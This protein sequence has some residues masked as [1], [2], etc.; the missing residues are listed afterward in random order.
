MIFANR[1]RQLGPGL[2]YAAAAIGVSHIVQATRAGALY[3]F[4]LLLAVL[5]I[6]LIKYPFFAFAPLYVQATQNSLLQGY[7][8][9]GRWA[10]I[11]F[12]VFSA[13]TVLPIVAAVTAVTVGIGLH[14]L[15]WPLTFLQFFVLLCVFLGVFLHFGKFNSLNNLIK[16]MVALLSVLTILAIIV[17]FSK[18]LANTSHLK[19]FEWNPNGIYFLI[20]LAGWMPTPID[21]SVWQ[22]L[23]H[24][25]QA[26]QNISASVRQTMADFNLGYGITIITALAFL[27]LGALVLYPQ[28]LALPTSSAQFAGIFLQNYGQIFGHWIK[29][30]VGFLAILA[31]L[32]TLLTVADA[33]PRVALAGLE[34]FSANLKIHFRKYISTFILFLILFGSF[35]LANFFQDNMLK[36]VDFATAASFIVAP[37]QAFLNYKLIYGAQSRVKEKPPQYLKYWAIFG[38]VFLTTFAI[39]YLYVLINRYGI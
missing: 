37:F 25:A 24:V 29:P 28:Q 30:F 3:G 38:L 27:A 39:A 5:I 14:V 26:K 1:W 8:Q 9:M 23:W 33:Y 36:M 17:A 7:H 10:S 13:L 31:M 32:S 6:N 34:L 11:G 22:S 20:I 16:W 4:D 15:E 35:L 19:G 2:L 21:A 12:L 18:P